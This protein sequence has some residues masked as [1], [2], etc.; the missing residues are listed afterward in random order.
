[1]GLSD[2]DCTTQADALADAHILIRLLGFDIATKAMN[3]RTAD[4]RDRMQG[5]WYLEMEAVG[6][7][8]A[9]IRR[10]G[11]FER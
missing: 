10:E 6:D 4:L 9:A 11:I 3:E 5:S 8:I 1:M 7:A 2:E